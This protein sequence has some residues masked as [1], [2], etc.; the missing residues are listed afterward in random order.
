MKTWITLLS[1]SILA[2]VLTDARPA[3]A[4][5]LCFPAFALGFG[6]DNG[7]GTT[8]AQLFGFG[9]FFLATSHASFAVVSVTGDIGEIEGVVEITTHHQSHFDVEVSGTFNLVTGAFHVSGPIDDGAGIFQDASGN[10]TFDGAE[11]FAT[12]QFHERINGR[13]CFDGGC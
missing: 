13:I 1:L 3:N 9:P 4:D 2:F 10:L 6:Q 7:D 11:D 5:E 8:D 12:G